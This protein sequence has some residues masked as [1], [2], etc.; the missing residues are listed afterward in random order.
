MEIWKQVR[1][2]VRRREREGSV[3]KNVTIEVMEYRYGFRVPYGT[4]SDEEKIAREAVEIVKKRLPTFV[5]ARK[6]FQS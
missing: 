1:L 5:Q 2:A 4:I 6:S 3:R